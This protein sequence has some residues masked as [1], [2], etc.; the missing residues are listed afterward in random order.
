M[1]I[2]TQSHDHS[3]P[4]N[5]TGIGSPYKRAI[6]SIT[7]PKKRKKR[8]KR[9]IKIKE[10]EIVHIHTLMVASHQSM[11]MNKPQW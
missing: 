5:P 7:S 6:E 10:I 3:F 9:K 11:A 4:T 2:V 1:G 8:K